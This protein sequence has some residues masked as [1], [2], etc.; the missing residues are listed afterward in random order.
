M[1][2]ARLDLPAKPY[3]RCLIGHG[4]GGGGGSAFLAAESSGQDRLRHMGIKREKHQGDEGVPN[5]SKHV[6]GSRWPG[7]SSAAIREGT[8]PTHEAT[9]SCDRMPTIRRGRD[10]SPSTRLAEEEVLERAVCRGCKPP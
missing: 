4:Q 6:S 2:R 3:H 1:T 10:L 7:C 8:E 5:G 9:P